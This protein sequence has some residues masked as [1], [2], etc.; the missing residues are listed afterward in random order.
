MKLQETKVTQKHQTTIPKEIREHL[1][2]KRGQTVR[3]HM[4]KTMVVVDVHGKVQEPVKFLT[5]QI[6]L[7]L[8]AVKLVSETREELA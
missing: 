5:S 8:D 1:K 7:D 3:W 4:V 2:L 6:Q